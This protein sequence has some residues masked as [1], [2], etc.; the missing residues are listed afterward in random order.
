MEGDAVHGL[1]LVGGASR[2]CRAL[3]FMVVPVMDGS[4][5]EISVVEE[6]SNSEELGRYHE[7]DN[8]GGKRGRVDGGG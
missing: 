8:D 6:G 5:H 7:H 3:L 4:Q 1:A 2:R